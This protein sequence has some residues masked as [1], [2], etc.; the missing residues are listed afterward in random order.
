MI[1]R[2][3][4]IVSLSIFLFEL[5]TYKLI[6]LNS[7]E[8][9]DIASNNESTI[10]VQPGFKEIVFNNGILNLIVWI[11]IATASFTTITLVIGIVINTKRN[12][13]IPEGVVVGVRSSLGHGDLDSAIATCE[14]NR[15]PL[16]N[17]LRTGFSNIYD[18]FEAIQEAVDTAT[19]LENEKILQHINYLNLCGQIAPMLGLL[20]T[21][22][23]MVSAFSSLAGEAGAAKTQLLAL[24]ISGALWTTVAGLLV[25]VPALLAY[26]ILKNSV[27]QTLLESQAIVLDI[28]KTLRGVKVDG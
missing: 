12:N 14:Q 26:T 1:R 7:A 19:E 4:V 24:A 25:S 17:I 27:T 15:G 16:S 11:M 2:V 22:I 6:A 3:F 13:L 8:E 28:M 9:T 20:G 21:V 23:G 18:G 5:S 10:I